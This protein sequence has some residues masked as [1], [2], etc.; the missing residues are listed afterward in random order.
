MV[1]M[2]LL[3]GIISGFGEFF[4]TNTEFDSEQYSVEEQNWKGIQL[5]VQYRVN[6][7]GQLYIIISLITLSICQD[8]LPSHLLY[9]GLLWTPFSL[10]Y[11]LITLLYMHDGC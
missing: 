5:W 4:S 2:S 7:A 6:M 9:D 11:G 8:P 1:E 10:C 3:Q